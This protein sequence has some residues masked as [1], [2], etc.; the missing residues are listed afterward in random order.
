MPMPCH[1]P[2]SCHAR[3]L[4]ASVCSWTVAH[5][6]AGASTGEVWRNQSLRGLTGARS[7]AHLR[8]AKGSCSASLSTEP[9]SRV[10]LPAYRQKQ[11]ARTRLINRIVP[12]AGSWSCGRLQ[13]AW[14]LQPAVLLTA[15]QV[16]GILAGFADELL[17]FAVQLQSA[18]G[19]RDAA[20][21]LR[22]LRLAPEIGRGGRLRWPSC[23]RGCGRRPRCLA[24]RGACRPWSERSGCVILS[25]LG[26]CC[27]AARRP[28]LRSV[29]ATGCG[30][31]LRGQL[32]RWGSPR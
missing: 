31:L 8:C 30:G 20:V 13:G 12:P 32:R 26:S 23:R 15:D 6:Q 3:T 7:T 29:R 4:A 22:L 27:P 24:G 5:V 21:H 28:L 14:T 25:A 9:V 16:V 18:L 11:V 1:V 17:E 2:V 10:P 19:P